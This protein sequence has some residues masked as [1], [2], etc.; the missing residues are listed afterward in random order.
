MEKDSSWKTYFSDKLRYADIINGIG[1]VGEQLVKATDLTEANG[2]ER[3]GKARD[4]LQKTAFGVNFALIGIEN[5]EKMDYELP[6]RILNYDVSVYEKQALKLRREVRQRSRYKG[7]LTAGE[8]YHCM[9]C[10]ILQTY[11]SSFRR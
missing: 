3:N 5:Q 4:L 7:Q 8:Y 9:R 1:C 6:L 10:W 2:Q 11:Q